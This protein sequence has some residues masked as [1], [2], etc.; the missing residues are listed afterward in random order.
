VEN[1]A[2]SRDDFTPIWQRVGE[3]GQKVAMISMDRPMDVEAVKSR[4]ANDNISYVAQ[5]QLEDGS[6]ALY[7]SSQTSNN[8][9]ILAEVTVNTSSSMKVAIRTETQ[10]LIPLYEALLSRRFAA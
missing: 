8:C 5:R 4:M 1:A 9:T 6:V 7:T 10:V 3:A 2:L